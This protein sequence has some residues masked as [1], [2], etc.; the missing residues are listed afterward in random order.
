MDEILEFG[1]MGRK[2]EKARRAIKPITQ[3]SPTDQSQQP[4]AY[5]VIQN[6]AAVKYQPAT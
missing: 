3:N 6:F 2:K 5:P 4:A 1:E